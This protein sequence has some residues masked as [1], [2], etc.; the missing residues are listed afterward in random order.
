MRLW[1]LHPKYLDQQGLCGLWRE[2]I[3]ARN[4]L[5]AYAN[6]T[7]HSHKNHPQLDRFK[8]ANPAE[9]NFYLYIIY[10]DSQE[11]GYNFDSSLLD[12]DLASET[13]ETCKNS[14][15]VTSGQVDF[16]ILHLSNKLEERNSTEKCNQLDCN[17]IPD[18]HP[19]FYMVNGDKVNWERG[20][21]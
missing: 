5:E 2:A 20:E 4:A 13:K 19:L 12:L 10:Q 1:S 17:G 14:I 11:R 8:S 21:L 15:S 7:E 18:L 6:Q 3:M 16:E 9:V